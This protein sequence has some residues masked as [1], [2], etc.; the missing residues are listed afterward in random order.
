MGARRRSGIPG[1]SECPGMIGVL[2][3]LVGAAGSLWILVVED[4]AIWG[5]ALLALFA[6]LGWTSFIWC[7]VWAESAPDERIGAGFIGVVV[8]GIGIGVGIASVVIYGAPSWSYILV[9]LAFAVFAGSLV[10]W[11]RT[12]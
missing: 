7:A 4:S 11:G 12:R 6:V 2:L 1:P 10:Q 5:V 8:G 3:S 9:G